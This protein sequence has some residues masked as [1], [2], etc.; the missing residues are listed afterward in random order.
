MLQVCNH[1]TNSMEKTQH[2][3]SSGFLKKKK[4]AKISPSP[5]AGAS[6]SKQ[7]DKEK[8]SKAPES[9]LQTETTVVEAVLESP[10][11]GPV[12]AASLAAVG[13]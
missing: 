5:E 13:A 2:C 6:S 9:T 12:A 8:P 11:T 7:T 10:A 4:K 3:P 1:I